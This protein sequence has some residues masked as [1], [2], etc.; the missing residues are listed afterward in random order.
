MTHDADLE[1]LKLLVA[2]ADGGSVGQAAR[3]LRISQPSASKRLATLERH[4][5]LELVV[6]TPRGSVVTAD[7]RQVVAWARDLLTAVAG[8]HA[9]V[10]RLHGARAGELRVAASMTIAEALVPTWL[11]DLRRGHAGVRVDVTVANSTEVAR[12]V[13]H[14][15]R[16]A[17]GFVEGPTVPSGLDS[18]VVGEDRLVVV[19]APGHPWAR[20]REPLPLAE[21]AGC[22]LAVRETGSGT[23]ETLDR[24]LH[25]RP[26]PTEL[27]LGS[28]AAVK[29][30]AVAGAAPAVLSAYAVAAELAT[31]QLVA[32]PVLA[33]AGPRRLRAVWPA[34]RTLSPLA[35][36][37]LRVIDRP[38][39]PG[40]PDG[41]R[42][43]SA[44]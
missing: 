10:A 43:A 41:G 5:G 24:I 13:R 38:S 4:L 36:D 28:N 18:R 16:I 26:G 2:V 27:A 25:T 42:V 11:R 12:L 39:A 1:S 20:R 7:G 40:G 31:G 32:V 19:V 35:R 6:R 17:L 29:G 9:D 3:S 21:L 34:G 8:F 22:T 15:E 37:L 30:A 44:G 23:R 14:D 33:L